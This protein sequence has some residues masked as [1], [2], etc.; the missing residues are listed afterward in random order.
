MSRPWPTGIDQS[1]FR[2]ATP[3][4]TSTARGDLHETTGC[5]GGRSRRRVR[6]RGGDRRRGNR[7]TAGQ[8]ADRLA[9]G[10]RTVRVAGRRGG[11]EPAVPAA[12]SG[13]DGRCPVSELVGSPS[14]V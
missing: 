12:K 1:T 5:R 8:Q 10:R 11:G 7:A 3:R 2:R 9:P 13:V 14:E 6:G 4:G